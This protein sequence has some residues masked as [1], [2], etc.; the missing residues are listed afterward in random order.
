MIYYYNI[1][2]VKAIVFILEIFSLVRLNKH[3]ENKHNH[4]FGKE[5]YNDIYK[6][7]DTRI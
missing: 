7:K 4:E 1:Y 3:K 6:A 2:S 5:N